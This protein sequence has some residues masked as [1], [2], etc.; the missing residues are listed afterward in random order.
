MV[1]ITVI[2]VILSKS[3]VFIF[4]GLDREE[5]QNLTKRKET[6]KNNTVSLKEIIKNYGDI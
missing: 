1:R 4:E 2:W 5:I 3:A 6:H